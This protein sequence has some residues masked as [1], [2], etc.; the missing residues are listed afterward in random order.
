[1]KYGITINCPQTL[2]A[3]QAEL[4]KTQWDIKNTICK[5]KEKQRESNETLAEIH[6]LMGN[7]STAKALK[8]IMNAEKM[9]Q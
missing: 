7:T 3:T 2:A 6:A 9:Q 1:M 5:S 4:S 8:S